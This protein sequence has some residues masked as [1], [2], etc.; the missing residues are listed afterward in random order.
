[1]KNR[2][3]VLVVVLALLIAIVPVYAQDNG[4]TIA[5]GDTVEG[6][7]ENSTTDYT[8]KLA[9]GEGI[10]LTAES[11]DFSPELTLSLDGEPLLSGQT[12]SSRLSFIA[13][14]AGDYTITVSDFDA[15]PATGTF[16]LTVRALPFEVVELNTPIEGTISET[17][18]YQVTLDTNQCVVAQL[19]APTGDFDA[20]LEL[21]NPAGLFVASNDDGGNALNSWLPYCASEG[22]QYTIVATG[23]YSEPVGAFTL[24]V[25]E[26]TPLAFTN[27]AGEIVEGFEETTWNTDNFSIEYTV[28][29]AT[30]QTIAVIA[31]ADSTSLYLE[32]TDSESDTTLAY[33]NFSE[34]GTSSLTYTAEIAGTYSILVYNYD[35]TPE[36]TFTISVQN[37]PAPIFVE[38]TD[39]DFDFGFDD[40]EPIARGAIAVGDTVEGNAEGANDVYTLTLDAESTLTISLTS[41]AFDAYV[42]V[43]DAEG[44]ELAFDDDGGGNLNSLLEITLA[45]GEYSIVVSS[46]FGTPSGPY[47]LTIE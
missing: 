32:L 12:F 14:D 18:G 5:I 11:F 46:F 16:T 40:L 31:T 36:S 45:P 15:T 21:L 41:A 22:G 42:S 47:T 10:V 28:E 37:A 13:T 2:A 9:A 30:E 39:V 17:T 44:A 8:I 43:E 24:V 27:P 25:E 4:Q 35:A 20:Y 7:L 26:T 23:F 19:V 34:T 33:S 29:L 38:G 6:T 3:I 1:M